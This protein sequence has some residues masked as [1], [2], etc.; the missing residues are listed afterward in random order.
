[1]DLLLKNIALH[2]TLTPQEQELVMSFCQKQSFSSKT[3]LICANSDI[4]PSYFVLK[5]ILRNYYLDSNGNEHTLSFS[6]VGW[7]MG[8][9]YSF[10]SQSPST[11]YIEVLEDSELLILTRDNQNELFSK[12]PKVER[13]FRILVERSL[14]ANQQRLIDNLSLTAEQ[15]YERFCKRYPTIKN[16]V[17]QKQ[18]ASYLGIT[19]EFFS[20]MKRIILKNL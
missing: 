12:V 11:S 3:K 10:L 15:R 4:S 19:P 18:I 5:G 1:M 2:I 7:W 14:I 16:C 6:P 9:M 8:D 13:Y 20:K 17:S